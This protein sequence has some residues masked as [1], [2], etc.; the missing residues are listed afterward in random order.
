MVEIPSA[1]ECT[2]LTEA[3]FLALSEM[4]RLAELGVSCK[5]LT[6][7]TISKPPRL[8]RTQTTLSA[9]FA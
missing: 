4:P 2:N 6:D 8:R 3:G 1:H 9:D 5:S 7:E